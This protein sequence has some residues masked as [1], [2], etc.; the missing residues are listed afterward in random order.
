MLSRLRRRP[1]L[2]TPKR[3]A[4]R[5]RPVRQAQAAA[6]RSV[7]A[8]AVHAVRAARQLCATRFPTTTAFTGRATNPSPQGMGN[9]ANAEANATSNRQASMAAAEQARQQALGQMG[10]A[11]LAGYGNAALSAQQS[12]CRPANGSEP[13]LCPTWRWPTKRHCRS[14]VS[15]VISPLRG[16]EPL[17]PA[18][19][20]VWRT[21]TLTWHK[22]IKG[23]GLQD[24]TLTH[25]SPLHPGGS[26][27]SQLGVAGTN[28]LGNLRGTAASVLGGLGQSA[29][30]AFRA[31]VGGAASGAM[32]NIG[33]GATAG[34]RK[35]GQGWSEM[36]FPIWAV[37]WELPSGALG[38]PPTPL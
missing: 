3:L 22:R 33:L 11:A 13:R 35:L 10:S 18:L 20:W 23:L 21:P 34:S 7:R 2:P 38:N 37:L 27:G 29:N 12:F 31:R 28:A 36:P 14:M 1:M 19:A 6:N 30:N 9:L 5:L 32:G 15:G 26:A 4:T 16:W 25:N 8:N 24:Q 17:T